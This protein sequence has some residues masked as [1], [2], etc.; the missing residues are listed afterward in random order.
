MQLG[1]LE[2]FVSDPVEAKSFYT[3]VL[4]FRLERV[5]GERFVWLRSGDTSLLLRPGRRAP[6]TADYQS[7][8]TGLVVY[9]DD[10]DDARRRLEAHGVVFRGTD[11]ERCL[12][13]T[14]PDGNWFQLVDPDDH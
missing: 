10:L 4:G 14:D 5:Q 12:T 2:I 6:Q 8:A 3:D 7:A 1:H 13:F 9:T 11:G